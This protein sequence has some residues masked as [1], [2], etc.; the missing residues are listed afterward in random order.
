M[1]NAQ[2]AG[3]AAAVIIG[4]DD[5]QPADALQPTLGPPGSSWQAP[6]AVISQASGDAV[7]E[8]AQQT[9]ELQATLAVPEGAQLCEAQQGGC[10]AA[11]GCSEPAS[12]QCEQRE[13]CAAEGSCTDDAG[14][15]CEAS[16]SEHGSCQAEQLASDPA[17]Y[18]ECSA[19][20]PV[21]SGTAM[22]LEV[23]LTPQVRLLWLA[24]AGDELCACL[25]SQHHRLLTRSAH[26][27]PLLQLTC[28]L[29]GSQ[30][31]FGAASYWLEVELLRS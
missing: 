1:L 9:P 26:A 19:G 6:F 21:Q 22:G 17:A 31:R 5:A 18:G 14:S 30:A 11:Q 27:M 15:P 29:E 24:V 10:A 23:V 20:D 7:R 8:R 4:A 25:H 2:A 16:N 12:G 13:A 3:A 28:M